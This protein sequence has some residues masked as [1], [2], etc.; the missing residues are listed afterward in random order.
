[1]NKI[2]KY[3]LPIFLTLIILLCIPKEG[4]YKKE[5]IK[6]N[7][8]TEQEIKNGI[9]YLDP[10]K[11]FEIGD[12]YKKITG[13]NIV[14]KIKNLTYEN[15]Y[16]SLNDLK[17]KVEKIYFE[18]NENK[19]ITIEKNSEKKYYKISKEMYKDI[20]R[21]S[22][23]NMCVYFFITIFLSFQIYKNKNN[24]EKK[25][26]LVILIGML[27][28]SVALKENI[29]TKIMAL[30]LSISFIIILIR[31]KNIEKIEIAVVILLLLSIISE[32]FGYGHYRV[33]YEQIQN[34]LLLILI[35]NNFNLQKND[36]EILKGIFKIVSVIMIIVSLISPCI[37]AGVHGFTYGIVALSL[38]VLSFDEL[39]NRYE[40]LYL[41][42][43]NA[44][45]FIL[46]IIGAV[47]SSR[48]TLLVAL[49]IWII[50]VFI[51]KIKIKNILL[52]I[53]LIFILG[54]G[55]KITFPA[56]F[57]KIEELTKSIK[58]LKDESNLQRL[59]MWRKSFYI[60]KENPILGI[61]TDS[62]YL[63]SQKMTYE[64][65]KDKDERFFDSFKH[66]H[67]EYLQQLLKYGIIGFIV[68]IYIMAKLIVPIF[69]NKEFS[70]E[71]GIFIIYSSYGIFEP[72][73]IRRESVIL[74][75]FISI[76]YYLNKKRSEKLDLKQINYIVLIPFLYGLIQNKRYR[77]YFPIIILFYFIYFLIKKRRK[78]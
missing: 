7:I 22:F 17:G 74:F 50:Y 29:Y 40:K 1:M 54:V 59:L 21:F 51:K 26:F 56:N 36:R 47:L 9:L 75:I 39:V 13:K 24:I 19:E 31:K 57:S 71:E 53:S 73:T 16:I 34:S 68:Y 37:L 49:V 41:K 10:G 65:I 52:M 46:G 76:A 12:F 30:L 58:N 11:G 27:F 32:K 70:F 67:N 23:V 60:I 61:G 2:K 28:I 78:K 42:I 72:Y 5:S 8:K 6:L 55:V 45:F 14:L 62:F 20:Y 4:Y 43:L 38:S 66:P 25:D 64:K 35:I 77:Y 63:E 18:N 15:Y 69:T 3:I 44:I 48:R 33:S